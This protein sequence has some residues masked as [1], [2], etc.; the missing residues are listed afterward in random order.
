MFLTYWGIRPL[1]SHTHGVGLGPNMRILVRAYMTFLLVVNCCCL[2]GIR[3][4][5]EATSRDRA[6]N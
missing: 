1:K 2:D 6:Q 4:L 3:C 5:V